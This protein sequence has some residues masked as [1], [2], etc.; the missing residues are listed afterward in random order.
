[1]RKL[2]LLVLLSGI[3]LLGSLA[4]LHAQT[5]T[6][7]SRAIDFIPADYAGYVRVNTTDAVASLQS[8]N[9][10]ARVALL[11]QPLRIP[12][13]NG[14]RLY[15]DFIPFQVLFDVDGTSFAE[16]ILPWLGSD[17]V[18]AYRQ[19]DAD[20]RAHVDDVLLIL[21]SSDMFGSTS[22]LSTIIQR[23]D[24][25]VES[26][27]RDVT[28]YQGDKSA[29]A[30]VESAVFIGPVEMIQDMLDVR[31][32]AQ[33]AL[34]DTPAFQALDTPPPDNAFLSAYVQGEYLIPALNGLLNGTRDSAPIVQAFG[35]ALGQE[36]FEGMLF[37]GGFSAAQVDITRQ[38][39]EGT[40]TA[41][42]RFHQPDRLETAII[43]A[44]DLAL[45][46]MLPQNALLVHTGTDFRQFVDN[47][48]TSL[49]LSN[50]SRELYPGLPIVIAGTSA[51]GLVGSPRPQ[52][53]TNAITTFRSVL[54]NLGDYNV[55]E[56]F[57]AHLTGSYAAALFPR[58]NSPI[59]VLNLPFD[60]VVIGNVDDGAA[61]QAGLLRLLQ[62]F[63]TLEVTP[64]RAQQGWRFTELRLRPTDPAPLFTI[65]YQE[66]RL[67]LATSNLADQ[68]LDAARGDNQMIVQPAWAQ[69][70]P[71]RPDL[72]VDIFGFYNTF[73][74]LQLLSGGFTFTE[75]DRQRL[76]L[77]T[78]YDGA[79]IYTLSLTATLPVLQ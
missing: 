18:V 57:L 59:P 36:S 21:S 65:G 52:D 19:F 15:Y 50:F 70:G 47:M 79:G 42:V 5:T 76:A 63:Y 44:Y 49:A 38:D 53:L 2:I 33:A 30:V 29:I 11:L 10:A 69:I 64:G 43:P 27:Y 9:E 60:G 40:L 67:L 54:E 66:N 37:S 24:L 32:D 46:E 45:L 22:A 41:Q 1:M 7:P 12:G 74:P 6:A 26:S 35:S 3:G 72:Y 16:N 4:P 62:T 55:Q 71:Q 56:D 73:F 8:L 28:L 25:R 23:Q 58:P 51:E 75:G 20:L 78:R 77:R 17:L 13:F 68:A 34:T 14:Q 31:A 61:A 48:L 39:E